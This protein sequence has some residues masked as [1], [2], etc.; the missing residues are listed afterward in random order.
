MSVVVGE[1]GGD[2]GIWR[3]GTGDWTGTAH[4]GAGGREQGKQLVMVQ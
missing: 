1:G 2:T 3:Q 4:Q